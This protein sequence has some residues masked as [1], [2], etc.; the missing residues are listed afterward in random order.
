MDKKTV[1]V[2]TTKGEIE[3]KD[4]SGS[5]SGDLRRALLLVDDNSTFDEISRRSAPSLRSVLPDIFSQ[6]ITGGYIY[7]KAKPFSVAQIAVPRAINQ[8]SKTSNDSDSDLD[9]TFLP[10]TSVEKTERPAQVNQHNT[11]AGQAHA[12]VEAAVEAAKTKSRAE[13]EAKALANAKL[14]TELEARKKL[15]AETR[16]KQDAIIRAQAEARAEATAVRIRAEQDAAR[17]RAEQEAARVKAE[18]EA[19]A[20]AEEYAI[21]EAERIKVEQENARL[22]AE[23]ELA[24]A[25]AEAEAKALAEERARQEV[26]RIKA[27]QEAARLKAEQEA[28]KAKAEAEAKAL[29]EERA[30]QEAARIKAEQE[31]ARLRAEQEAA[32]AKAEAEAKALAEERARQE[33]ARIKAEQEA[34]RLRAEQEAAKAKAEAEAKELA[35]ERARQEAARIKAE[36]EVSRIKAEQEAAR[37]RAEQEAAKTKSEAEAKAMAEDRARQKIAR[38]KTEQE[39]ARIRAEL[40]ATMAKAEAETRAMAEE[41]NRQQ[42]E[43][44]RIKGEN[45]AARSKME[46]EV[47]KSNAVA[48]AEA[49]TAELASQAVEPPQHREEQ[50]AAEAFNALFHQSAPAT[51]SI[52]FHNKV[53]D[54]GLEAERALLAQKI[55]AQEM[56]ILKAREESEKLGEEQAKTWAE[57]ERRAHDRAKI[58]SSRQPEAPLQV[59]EPPQR[60]MRA[61]RK[62]LPKGKIISAVVVLLFLSVWLFPYVLPMD[63]YIAPVEK[64]LSEQ[65][66]QPV[67]VT[68]LHIDSLPLP[69]MQL[70]NV[71]MGSGQELKVG[72]VEM[73]FDFFSIFS[74][75]KNIRNIELDDVTLD[76]ASLEKE[77][78][79]LQE[80]GANREYLFSHITFRHIKFSSSEI[81]LPVFS[82][83]VEITEQ[84]KIGKISIKSED[85]KFDLSIQPAQDRLQIALNAKSTAFPLFSNVLFDDFS[86]NIEIAATGANIADIDAQAYGGFLHGNAK[87]SWQNGWLFQGRVNAK[88]VELLK[89]FPKD[90]VSGE[91]Q[92]DSNFSASGT[93]LGLIT[94]AVQMDGSFVV[95]KGAINNMDMVETVRQGNRQIGK[96]HFDELTGNFQSNNRGQSFQQLQISSG[97]LSGS[98]SFEVTPDS[99]LS[100]RFSIG[101]KARAGN[102][103]LTLSGTLTDPV[104]RSGKF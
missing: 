103:P 29:A 85:N 31:A 93:K 32:K 66:K 36:Q 10:A 7:D 21:Q 48:E 97:I 13:A 25:K 14:T 78:A 15:E 70:E 73:T 57:A 4:N 18:A 1:F 99:Q 64:R 61:P 101:L 51:Q 38:I 5:L 53:N 20:L 30:R 55:A 92:G 3:V 35:E 79:W 87:V 40:E 90:G 50:A 23:L 27:E 17:F 47:A 37:L 62:P 24:K 86:A 63:G 102:S 68:A 19:K 52:E 81:T 71:T 96:T 33:A 60:K 75:V 67:H 12:N 89:L 54:E 22:K 82:G 26:A 56:A 34:A 41:R 42:A 72:R 9:F 59:A 77:S 76:T 69:K 6:L 45:E 2:K 16:A 84:G 28:A 88:S 49:R 44:L 43:A 8:E 104:L 80:I 83:G 94:N 39:S 74:T 11:I 65:F 95:K 58:E 46:Q 91:L 100:G 98:G